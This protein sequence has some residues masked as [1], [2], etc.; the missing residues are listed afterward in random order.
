[1]LDF[2]GK[3]V[4][5]TGASQGI[6]L[7]IARSFLDAGADVH[8]TGTRAKS[9]AY[10]DDLSS[11]YYHQADLSCSEGRTRLHAASPEIDVLVN[12]A[13]FSLEDEFDLDNFRR[14]IEMNLVSVM[15]LCCLYHE[16]L[17]QRGGAIVNVGSVSSHV[18][19]KRVPG[20]TASKS[21]LLGL[22][23]ALADKWAISGPRVNMVAPGFVRTRLN[24]HIRKE[25]SREKR[26]L[27]TIPMERWGEP[28][29]I[30]GAVLF[31]SSSMASYITGISLPI[32][33]G[34]LLR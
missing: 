13:G 2:T 23:K 17:V 11:F 26:L 18:A 10:A 30:S 12:N 5:V 21:G 15:E 16:T 31:L 1:M 24:E 33:G 25:E 34:L 19:L 27:E 22:T 3:T 6:G 20:Y 7:A 4:M 29:E 28:D 32:D 8:I 9:G 14:V